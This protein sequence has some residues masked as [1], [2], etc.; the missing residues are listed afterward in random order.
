MNIPRY[1]KMISTITQITLAQPDMSWRRN[2]SPKTVI[3]NQNHSTKI[4][5][6]KTS[7]RKLEKVKPPENNISSSLERHHKKDPLAGPIRQPEQLP[8]KKQQDPDDRDRHP[9]GQHH[10]DN[11]S[12]TRIFVIPL[13]ERDEQRKIGHQRRDDVRRRVA[14]PVGC[15]HGLGGDP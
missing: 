5:I 4:K 13:R 11:R 1:G 14:Y 7:A 15:Q 8:T 9:V 10:R 12:D 2:R 3:S 6:D